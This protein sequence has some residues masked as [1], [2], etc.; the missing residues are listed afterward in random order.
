MPT[1]APSSLKRYPVALLVLWFTGAIVLILWSMFLCDGHLIYTLDDPY[2]HLRVAQNILHGSYG[3]N[4]G[5]YSSPSSS[6]IYPYL[7]AFTEFA[8]FGIWGPL[9]INMLAMALAVYAVGRIFRDYV[10]TYNINDSRFVA[11]RFFPFALGILTCFLMNAWGL[12]MTGMEHSLHVLA[13]VLVIWGFLRILDGE[14]EFPG[15]LIPVIVTLPF[16]RFEGFA[17]SLFSVCAL[18]YLGHRFRALV[19]MLLI[20]FGLFC[21]FLFTQSKGLPV[22]PGSV[23]LKSDFAEKAAEHASLVQLLR[24]AYSNVNESINNLQGI[25]LIISLFIVFI[26]TYKAWQEERYPIAMVIAGMMIVTVLAHIFFGRYDGF[27]RYEIYAITLNMIC[28]LILGRTYFFRKNV[29]AVV[30]LAFLFVAMR[31][32]VT[33]VMTPKASQ[34]IYQQQYQM[35]RFAV[36]YWRQPVGVNDLGLVSY[37][38]PVYVLDL[39]GL[40]SEEVRRLRM[41]EG[42]YNAKTLSSLVERRHISLIMIYEF[43][44]K[45]MIPDEWHKVAILNTPRCTVASNQ[46]SFYITPNANRTKVLDLLYQFAKTLPDGA[47]LKIIE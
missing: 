16:I 27:S 22:L 23:L 40:G 18:V 20:M 31:Y 24:V 2:I 46:V 13:V 42:G 8:G 3:I 44:Y 11:S 28:I 1:T 37:G 33:T 5:E 15:W 19:A 21:W 10:F 43:V 45:S 6:V 47:V 26:L 32:I 38:N 9:V 30:V 36:D 25:S 17:M 4:F 34:N 7:L 39:Y 14:S 41:I 35:H 29:G 12:V